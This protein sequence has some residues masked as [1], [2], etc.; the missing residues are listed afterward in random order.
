MELPASNE[1]Q[2]TGPARP[3][4]G[5]G[6]SARRSFRVPTLGEILF[7]PL[8]ELARLDLGFKNLVCATALPDTMDLDIHAC[9]KK[10]HE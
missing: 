6:D 7:W 3:A 10:L 5:N 4:N 9:L 1:R 2:V 8:N